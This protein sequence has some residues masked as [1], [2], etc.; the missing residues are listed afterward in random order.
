MAS[1]ML[2]STDSRSLGEDREPHICTP[3]T[4]A[5]AKSWVVEYLQVIA[6]SRKEGYVDADLRHC[7]WSGL[8]KPTE[9]V[10]PEGVG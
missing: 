4:L 2:P 9:R 10:V 7:G 6:Q 3:L 5:E 8:R 1:G